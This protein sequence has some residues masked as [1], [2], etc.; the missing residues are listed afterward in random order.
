MAA[1]FIA[2]LTNCHESDK[3]SLLM[4][5][6]DVIFDR[7]SSRNVASRSVALLT[8]MLG[9]AHVI[10]RC[11]ETWCVN[12]FSSKATMNLAH[13][14]GSYMYYFSFCLVMANTLMPTT[15]AVE[16]KW[17]SCS[18]DS[19]QFTVAGP[20]SYVALATGT[21]SLLYGM[22]VQHTTAGILRDQRRTV[23]ADGSFKI[24]ET[25]T[26]PKKGLFTY[27]SCPHYLGEVLVYLGLFAV[28]HHD[29]NLLTLFVFTLVNQTLSALVTH[30][31][32]HERFKTYPKKRK[33][34]FP[35]LL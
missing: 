26:I 21:L 35:Y 7:S 4:S 28:S 24:T 14:A 22:Y 6:L 9:Y 11:Y 13:Y 5:L 17:E 20:V 27:V 30:K 34:I 8:F 3:C 29:V 2:W 12:V 23:K 33:A 32:Y 15:G 25:Y 10:R 16:S 1:L 31:W 19:T 18:N